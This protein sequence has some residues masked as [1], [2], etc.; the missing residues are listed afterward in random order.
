V[1]VGTGAGFP[2][3]AIKI[4]RPEIKMTL[5]ESKE[6]KVAFLH[7]MT[8][9]LGLSGV[10]VIHGRIGARGAHSNMV[11]TG[12]F[13]LLLSRAVSPR[14]ILKDSYRIVRPGGRILLFQREKDIA[15][16]REYLDGHHDIRIEEVHP[17]SFSLFPVAF[18]LVLLTCTSQGVSK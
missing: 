8:G 14:V 6:K 11:P 9:R 3:L 16:T 5:V 12:P 7:H 10:S 15:E 1:D 2:G 18:S 4:A 17:M 13:D